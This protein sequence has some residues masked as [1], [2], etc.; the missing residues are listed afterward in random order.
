MKK[1][2]IVFLVSMACLVTALPVWACSVP[3]FRY[4]LERWQADPYEVVVFHRGS[5]TTE[6]QTLSDQLSEQGKAGKVHANLNLTTVDLDADPDPRLLQ[7]WE[8][9]QEATLPWMVVKYPTQ[10]RIPVD[11]FAGPLAEENVSKL[12]DSPLR[13]E[14]ARRLLTGDTAVWVLLESGDQQQ[15]DAAFKLVE[16]QAKHLATVLKLPE[17]DEADLDEVSIDP[18][19]LT[20][21]FSTVRLS[22][23]NP[24]ETMLVN[25]LLGSEEDLRDLEGAMAFPVFGRGRV[26]YSLIG[27]GITEENLE[28]AGVDLTGPCTCTVKDQNPGVD[29]VMAVDWDNLVDR[30]VEIDKELPPLSGLGGFAA[31][32]DSTADGKNE[33]SIL[34]EESEVV[35]NSETAEAS[36]PAVTAAPV[37]TEAS[38][39][40]AGSPIVRNLLVLAVVAL[41]CVIGGSFVLF[42]KQT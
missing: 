4:A 11:M 23:E 13:R 9:Q 37:A 2:S 35:A 29:L 19:A 16:Q 41:L 12:L 24:D 3:V 42:R 25:M 7:I 5:M 15:D 8:E 40:A 31:T 32:E 10:T 21:Q 34:D 30:Q 20:L 18:T 22:R 26:L 38:K 1:K 39:D 6:Q 28:Q 33:K 36:S 27:E 14:I 17:I